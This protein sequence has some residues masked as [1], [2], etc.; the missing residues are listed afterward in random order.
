MPFLLLQNTINENRLVLE[1]VE[2]E[3]Y[4]GKASKLTKQLEDISKQPQTKENTKEFNRILKE[5]DDLERKHI[6]TDTSTH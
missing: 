4:L 6:S 3:D 2:K 1:K 5:R